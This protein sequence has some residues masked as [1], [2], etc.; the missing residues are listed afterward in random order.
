[1]HEQKRNTVLSECIYVKKSFHEMDSDSNAQHLILLH[2]FFFF[3][4]RLSKMLHSYF[5]GKLALRYTSS[6][7]DI[8]I[9]GQTQLFT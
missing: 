7:V 3:L 9:R 5:W 2:C 4:H 1:M 8:D 6:T